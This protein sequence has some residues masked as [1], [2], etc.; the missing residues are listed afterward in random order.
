MKKLYIL[1]LSAVGT[2]S[3]GQTIFSEN[4]G[5]PGGTTLIPAYAT[6]TAPATFQSAAPI[7]FSGTADARATQPS[8]VYTGATGGGN[9]FL[10]S[11]TDTFQIDGINT[12]G[13]A[14]ANLRLSFGINTPTA[15][16]NLLVVEVSTN[17]TTFTPLS[18]TPTAAGWTLATITSGIPASAT[19]S[20]RFSSTSATL[21]FRVDD[22][23]VFNFNP[24]CTLVLDPTTTV[25]DAITGA[26]D[27]Y[28]ATIPYTGGGTG[29][30]TV[31]RTPAVGTIGGSN[32]NT[33]A[34]GDIVI[35][36]IPEGTSLV[37]N[38]T[39]GACSYATNPIVQDC[40]PVN[41]LPFSESFPYAAGADLGATQ[42]W[43]NVNTGDQILGN[44]GSLNY[45][46]LVSTGNSVTFNGA[47]TDN[48]TG[49]TSTTAGT[50]YASF[51]MNVTDIA[52]LTGA[53]ATTFFCGLTDGARGYKG[54][55]FTVKNGTQYQFGLDA[56]S[57]TTNIDPTLR[58]VGDVTMVV[59]GY[60]FSTLTLKLWVN[61]NLATF[62]AATT[63]T[64]S[65]VLTTAIADLAGFLLRQDT[66]TTTP[67]IIFDELKITTTIGQ[68]LAVEQVNQNIAGL[69]VFVNNK[70]LNVTS[71]NTDTKSVQ[72]FNMI[73]K[74][75][76]A[77]NVTTQTI[78]VAD[79]A[80]GV[81]IIKVTE[82]GS[83]N[84]IKMVIE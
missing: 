1:L 15:V 72:I 10:N 31:T 39:K 61:P 27:T 73:G 79:L 67:T 11:A 13:F 64:L 2:L 26:I 54:R 36:G 59:L 75:V 18:Y 62:T 42:N 63:P 43:I 14:T 57:T 78:N 22:V 65:Q 82:N 49:F 28:T 40:K 69:K 46:G 81:Y 3:F 53:T 71:D 32:I 56:A 47:G 44:A 74:Q 51:L 34:A 29:G 55:V 23:K 68:I 48:F 76:I 38:I 66:A 19:L 84:T 25:C 80:T 37:V 70:N 6:G 30:F 4:M 9:I 41:T 35:S 24:A 17:G 83:S 50:I 45:T 7:A 33:T 16:T 12:S 21:Q 8:S 60:D 20:I 58:N 77:T 52:N 5:T